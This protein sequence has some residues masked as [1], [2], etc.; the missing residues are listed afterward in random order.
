MKLRRKV[1]AVTLAQVKADQLQA[2]K[3]RDTVKAK[4]LTTLL[5]ETKT[6]ADKNAEKEPR[7]ANG[8]V[9][10]RDPTD[11]EVEATIDSFL[12][13]NREAQEY[14]AKSEIHPV[15]VEANL[16]EARAEEA[17]LLAYKPQQLTAEQIEQ[18]ITDNFSVV[19]NKLRGQINLYFKAN[20]AGQYDG[21]SL[22]NA[23]DK[24]IAG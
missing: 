10:K 11:G 7:D 24:L 16:A 20:Y 21:M 17:I 23:I 22:K 15:A 19:E 1:M 18:I 8:S 12:K 3:D 4:L 13:K 5:G 14:M 9:V 2:R 6:L